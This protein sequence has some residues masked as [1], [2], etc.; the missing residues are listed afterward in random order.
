MMRWFSTILSYS[1]QTYTPLTTFCPIHFIH[2]IRTIVIARLL[3]KVF[4]SSYS[5]HKSYSTAISSANGDEWLEKLKKIE[6]SFF[7]EFIVVTQLVGN[8][9]LLHYSVTPHV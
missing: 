2:F 5:T 4:R 3:C 6:K 1:T 9:I 7:F 8:F